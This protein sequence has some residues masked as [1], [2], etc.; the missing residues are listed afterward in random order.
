MRESELESENH[1]SH[2]FEWRS[3]DTCLLCLMEIIQADYSSSLRIHRRSALATFNQR[4]NTDVILPS[5]QEKGSSSSH[6]NL[7]RLLQKNRNVASQVLDT[8][9][10][11]QARNEKLQFLDSHHSLIPCIASSVVVGFI[12]IPRFLILFFFF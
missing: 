7:A 4:L 10:G 6:K 3:D 2:A 9:L 11:M 12:L 8:L 1:R 5:Q